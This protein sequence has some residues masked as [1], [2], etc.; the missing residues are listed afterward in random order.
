MYQA[1]IRLPRD[2]FNF[3]SLRKARMITINIS[4][5]FK[6]KRDLE[7][8]IQYDFSGYKNI[9]CLERKR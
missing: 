7:K 6:N 4:S 2:V 1:L 5:T 9:S 3:C 8:T